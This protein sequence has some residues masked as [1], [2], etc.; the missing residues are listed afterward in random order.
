MHRA[1]VASSWMAGG[2]IAAACAALLLS[3]CGGPRGSL[4]Q[5][6]IVQY[7]YNVDE[8]HGLVRVLGVARNTGS[9]RTPKAEIVATL[10]GRTGSLKGQ[11][12][13]E[14]P[15]LDAG[16]QRLFSLLITSHGKVDAVDMVVVPPGTQA[17][18]GNVAAPENSPVAGDQ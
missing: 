13:C 4:D 5:I 12:R 18:G 2:V 10:R 9:E 6:N 14:L 3:G 17:E 7:R 15:S 1:N 11:N 8:A 16:A